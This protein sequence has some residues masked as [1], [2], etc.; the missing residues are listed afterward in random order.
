MRVYIIVAAS[1]VLATLVGCDGAGARQAKSA[2]TRGTSVS[3]LESALP[4]LVNLGVVSCDYASERR[5]ASSGLPSPSDVLLELLGHASLGD[6]AARKLRDESE[7]E[8]I[9]RDKV[10]EGLRAILPAGEILVC[11]RLNKTFSQNSTYAHGF[12]VV[13]KNDLS[14]LYFIARDLDHPIE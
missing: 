9:E 7:W 5:S 10:P 14:K 8:P 4:N 3:Q 6:D 1:A 2:S 12:V 11:R 13:M